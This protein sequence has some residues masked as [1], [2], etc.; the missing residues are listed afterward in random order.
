MFALRSVIAALPLLFSMAAHAGDSEDVQQLIRAKQFPQA[1]ERADKALSKSP[2][3]AQLRFLR[4]IALSE[5]GRTD[6]AIKAFTKL[7]EDYPQLPEPYNNLAVLYANKGQL[8]KS[9]AALQ[10]AIQTNPSYAIAHENLGDLYA[11]LASQAYDK[12]LQ[13]EG[14]NPQ[15]QTKLKLVDSLFSQQGNRSPVA[16]ATVAV[17]PA[18]AKPVATTAAVNTKPAPTAAPT[19][20]VTIKPTAAPKATATPKPTV[21]PTAVPTAK[22]TAAPTAT[23]KASPAPTEA[24]KTDNAARQQVIASVEG[25]AGAWS[26]QNVNGYINSY[27]K[28]FKAPG[29]RAAWEKDRQAKISA[30]K[31][32]DVNVRDIKVEM[33]DDNTA[34]VRLRQDYKSDRLSTSTSK[35]LI[36]EKSG[37]RWLIREERIGG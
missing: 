9:R 21:A 19:A 6:E 22:A 3:D 11:R 36:L 27:S 5:M 31:S 30:P 32:I 13:L 29:G 16:P 2:K 1:L 25:W 28:N 18:A 17:A 24:P 7:S 4:G 12:A 37:G 26:R 34:K 8:D 23:P 35:T 15:V 10:M 33:I 20:V 14:A